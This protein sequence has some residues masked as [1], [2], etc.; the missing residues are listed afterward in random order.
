MESRAMGLAE[1]LGFQNIRHFGP[2]D[3]AEIGASGV[4]S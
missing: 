4:V 1:D 3:R 2:P